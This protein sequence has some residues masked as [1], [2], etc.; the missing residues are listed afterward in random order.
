[1][2]GNSRVWKQLWLSRFIVASN[3]QVG[4]G[5]RLLKASSPNWLPPTLLVQVSEDI[6]IP[7][8]DAFPDPGCCVVPM[9]GG[10]AAKVDSNEE[11]LFANAVVTIF[12]GRRRKVDFSRP[13]PSPR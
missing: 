3:L 4:A 11:S 10:A 5:N 2:S 12:I 8:P 13:R 9:T 1:M 7:I 6:T